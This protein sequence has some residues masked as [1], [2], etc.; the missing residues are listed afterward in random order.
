MQLRA[1]PKLQ[2]RIGDAQDA[3]RVGVLGAQ[4]FLDA[5]AA[6]GISHAVAQ[7]ALEYF[8]V[9]QM[10]RELSYS[11]GAFILVESQGNLIGFAQLD[12]LSPQPLAPNGVAVELHRLYVHPRFTGMGLGT[13]LLAE[14]E[15]WA[16]SRSAASV[17]ATVWAKSKRALA[18]FSQRGYLDVGT[19]VYSTG[20]EEHENRILVHA[21]HSEA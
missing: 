17:W 5:Y 13:A 11:E 19:G 21:A 4:V 2:F 9:E 8:T 18:F 20:T 10:T 3:S 15:T 6:D 7:E 16:R 12:S 14:A 1:L